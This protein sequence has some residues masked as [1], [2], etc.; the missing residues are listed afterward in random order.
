MVQLW[1]NS[2]AL[3][4]GVHFHSPCHRL[5]ILHHCWCT[6]VAGVCMCSCVGGCALHTHVLAPGLELCSECICAYC[7]QTLVSNVCPCC[8]FLQHHKYMCA[9]RCSRGILCI[10]VSPL[11]HHNILHGTDLAVL[12]AL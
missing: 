3:A 10:A 4:M 2:M 11:H 7:S 12:I 5:E 8:S 6:Y 9:V 1:Y